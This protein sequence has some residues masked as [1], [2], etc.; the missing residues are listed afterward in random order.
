MMEMKWHSFTGRIGKGMET[1]WVGFPSLVLEHSEAHPVH[2]LQCNWEIW[3]WW[4]SSGR[5]A[6]DSVGCRGRCERR[7][8]GRW[9]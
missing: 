9:L 6:L 8:P 7:G 3:M 5:G 1:G 4:E 2:K